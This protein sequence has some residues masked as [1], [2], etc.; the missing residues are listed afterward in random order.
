M[1][2]RKRKQFDID[3]IYCVKF[4]NIYLPCSDFFFKKTVIANIIYD[5][6]G[7]FRKRREEV[8]RKWK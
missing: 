3:M 5:H 6:N 2:S 7:E 8:R 4:I 1:S